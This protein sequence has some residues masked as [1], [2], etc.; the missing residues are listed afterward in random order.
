M[1]STGLMVAEFSLMSALR[2]NLQE[3]PKEM[4]VEVIEEIAH[5]EEMVE[6]SQEAEEDHLL[7]TSALVVANPVIGR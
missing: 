4:V 7:A 3:E 2:S 1:L 5:Q 6:E